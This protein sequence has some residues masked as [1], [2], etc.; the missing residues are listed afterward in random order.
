MRNNVTKLNIAVNRG[1]HKEALEAHAAGIC[2]IPVTEDGSKAPWPWDGTKENKTQARTWKPYQ[3]RRPEAALL[4]RWFGDLERSGLGM[5]T[6]AV[7]GRVETW[8]F[9]DYPTYEAFVE[10][11]RASGLGSVINRVEAGYCDATAGG[12]VRW[13]VRYPEGVE[14]EPGERIILARRPKRPEEM[15][16]K[17]DRTKALIEMPAFSIM[18]PS[19]GRVHPTHKAYTRRSG[20]FPTIASYT[21]EE[22]EALIELA[23]SF[24]QMDRE[25]AEPK[26]RKARTGNQPTGARPGDE[27]AADVDWPDVLIDWK[28]AYT[29]AGVSYW[30][31]PGKKYG[32]SATTNYGGC[33]LF[34]PF[35]SST[36]FD[37]AK[38]YS[39][40]A[41]YAVINHG[42][43]FGQAAK[44]LREKGYGKKPVF[45]PRGTKVIDPADIGTDDAGGTAS[46]QDHLN[47]DSAESI[48]PDETA[49]VTGKEAAADYRYTNLGMQWH[50]KTDK[51]EAWIPLTNFN[52][53]IVCELTYDDG[54]ETRK[55]FGIV[56]SRRNLTYRFSVSA[57]Q[58]SSMNWVPEQIGSTAYVEP[59]QSTSKRAAVAIQVLSGD[60]PRRTVYGHTGWQKIGGVYAYL[61]ADGAIG[62]NGP[63][64]NIVVEL[65]KE[66]SLAVLPDPGDLDAL[67]AAVRASIDLIDLAQDTVSVSLLG[68]TY[69]SVL[70]GGDISGGVTGE[71]G[72][73]KTAFVVLMQAHF[74]AGF[75][76]AHIPANWSNTPNQLEELAFFAKDMALMIDEYMPGQVHFDRQVYQSKAERVLRNQGNMGGR[77]RM[78]KDRKL[79]PSRPPRGTILFTGEE[80]PEGASLRARMAAS[81]I[82]PGSIDRYKLTTAQQLAAKGTYASA[83]AGFIQYL[84]PQ[85]EEA[86]AIFKIDVRT[87][88]EKALTA[89]HS[90][91]ADVMGQLMAAWSMWLTYATDIG[92]ISEEE[93]LKLADRVWQ[94]LLV[95][96]S[97]QTV[98]QDESDP[99]TKFRDLL[100][101]C[102]R[103]GKAHLRNKDSHTKPPPKAGTWG[104]VEYGIDEKTGEV[105][106]EPKGT[107]VGWADDKYVYLDPSA[108]FKVTNDFSV[109]GLGVGKN[110][111][112]AALR[113][114][115]VNLRSER[116]GGHRRDWRIDLPDGRRVGV[117]VCTH[118]VE[119]GAKI[120]G[121]NGPFGPED[122]NSQ[123]TQEVE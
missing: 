64:Q 82:Q 120:F 94:A 23:R 50:R 63:V 47:A 77:G 107:P 98:L 113:A 99:V 14:R 122:E 35:T 92:A 76:A 100:F 41:A 93:A 24:D 95:L 7:S 79:V 78:S 8:D 91:T 90:R 119:E 75:D 60:V 53:K 38:A 10:L 32:I 67:K 87:A 61:H 105:L 56:A 84:A 71:T 33:D 34:Y 49:I 13:P 96:G 3:F 59:G 121:P 28:K 117:W 112:A 108:V 110:K 73:F 16:H 40:F 43:D 1:V 31:R 106:M 48:A 88:R 20:G 80:L 2:V 57:A 123:Q 86:Q 17:K 58:F 45:T 4:T 52:A 36:E 37:P 109:G 42:G 102:F 68:C 114:K 66:L 11:A 55:E 44:A 69:R 21:M 46:T 26:P 118:E 104:W 15:R 89:D 9:D 72:N 12:G 6:G 97:E 54:V 74:G 30:V 25:P 81:E 27:Y 65:P 101:S 111:L 19:N 29:R 18:A 103:A 116:R 83:M 39:K 70:G 85:F 62:P 22:R 115:K 51:G 5:V